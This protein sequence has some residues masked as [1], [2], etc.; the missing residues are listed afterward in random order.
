MKTCLFFAFHGNLNFGTQIVHF[1]EE[2]KAEK[3]RERQET[4]PDCECSTD[5][6]R[7]R[8]SRIQIN[9]KMGKQRNTASGISYFLIGIN[10]GLR[11]GDIVRIKVKDVQK[12]VSTH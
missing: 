3:E 11:V 8:N 1:Q 5:S 12:D 2:E 6:K 10:T 9:L 7:S 4:D